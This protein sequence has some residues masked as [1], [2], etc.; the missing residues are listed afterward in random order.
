MI[1]EEIRLQGINNAHLITPRQW[2]LLH[3]VLIMQ[4]CFSLLKELCEAKTKEE[5]MIML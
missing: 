5:A 2:L 4:S 3:E 1:H